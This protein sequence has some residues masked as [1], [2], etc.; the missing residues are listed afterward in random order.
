MSTLTSLVEQ[1]DWTL[2]L[3]DREYVISHGKKFMG[4]FPCTMTVEQNLSFFFFFFSSQTFHVVDTLT[5]VRARSQI[6]G[7]IRINWALSDFL[8]SQLDLNYEF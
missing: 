2:S 4:F 7:E 1:G 8:F 3:I 6:F 5:D